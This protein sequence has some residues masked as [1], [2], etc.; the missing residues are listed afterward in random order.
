MLYT[1]YL[2]VYFPY[3]GTCMSPGRVSNESLATAGLSLMRQ[4]GKPLTRVPTSTRAMIYSENSGKTVRLRTCNDH[5]LVVVADS[6]NSDAKLN[7]EGTDF[8]LIVM[9]ETPRTPGPVVAYLVPASV[10]AAAARDTH[11]RWLKTKPRTKGK[12]RTWNLWFDDSGPGKASGFGK[13]WES[14]RLQGRANT[15]GSTSRSSSVQTGQPSLN[16]VI[17]KARREISEAAGVP[18]S[19]V[20]ISLDLT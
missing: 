13:K 5:L 7:I 4:A 17:S 2:T 14:Y 1:G 6:P 12:N 19:A 15:T 20:R 18:E 8:V 9:P 11:E 16:D 10:V 3:K